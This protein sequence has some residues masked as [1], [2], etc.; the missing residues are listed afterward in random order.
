[1]LSGIAK[2]LIQIPINVYEL[3]NTNYDKQ[4]ILKRVENCA[5]EYMC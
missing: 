5:N 1:M 3:K 4:N 2:N